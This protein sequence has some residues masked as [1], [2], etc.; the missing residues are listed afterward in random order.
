MGTPSH[1]PQWV[2]MGPTSTISTAFSESISY[3]L[4]SVQD[5]SK[6]CKN[7][8]CGWEVKAE[9]WVVPVPVPP[10][11]LTSPVTLCHC[12]Q[13]RLLPCLCSALRVTSLS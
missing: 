13:R 11:P 9:H 8:L 6:L 5:L 1:P 4:H 7:K 12:L 3:Y 2:P 10:T